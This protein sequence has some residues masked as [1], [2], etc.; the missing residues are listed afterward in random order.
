[1]ADEADN[2]RRDEKSSRESPEVSRRMIEPEVDREASPPGRTAQHAGT[3]RGAAS[4]QS[5]ASMT[6]VCGSASRCGNEPDLI[7]VGVEALDFQVFRRRILGSKPI[8][9]V[10]L[11]SDSNLAISLRLR[12]PR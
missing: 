5:E 1:M 4:A 9:I 7:A 11:H 12:L 2:R 6:R 10:M 3:A 8:W